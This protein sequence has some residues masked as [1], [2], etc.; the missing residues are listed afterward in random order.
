MSGESIAT[1]VGAVIGGAIGFGGSYILFLLNWRK[2]S[3]E[4]VRNQAE[5]KRRL[6]TALLAESIVL[7]DR[8]LEV[9]G[10][11][12]KDWNPGHPIELGGYVRATNIFA[13]YDANT[14]GIGLFEPEDAKI[15]VRAYTLAKSHV[16]G[17]SNAA[18]IV[19][20]RL[21]EIRPYQIVENPIGKDLEANLHEYIDWIGPT[22]KKESEQVLEAAAQAIAVLEKNCINPSSSCG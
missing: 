10:T 2:E 7:R 22:L 19:R 11:K 18:E 8:Y 17:I 14:S 12:I 4:Q 16:E 3:A 15:I 1:L 5:S 6:A 13:V 9:M 20:E 21:S